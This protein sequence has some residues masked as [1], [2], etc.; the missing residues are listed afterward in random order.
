M[1]VYA[2][3]HIHMHIRIHVR[4]RITIH[5]HIHT[6]IRTDRRYMV[7]RCAFWA[8]PHPPCMAFPP[9]SARALLCSDRGAIGKG[10]RET[11]APSIVTMPQG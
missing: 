2:Y 4:I 8:S 11:A 9:I 5:I 10:R 1:C 3:L 7:V 6:C